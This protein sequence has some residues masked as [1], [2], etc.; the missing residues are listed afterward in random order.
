MDSFIQSSHKIVSRFY[1]NGLTLLVIELL[2]FLF[3]NGI[4]SELS[5]ASSV[6]SSKSA[7]DTSHSYSVN[8]SPWYLNIDDHWGGHL[9]VRGACSWP[10]SDSFFRARGTE[11][12]YDGHAEARVK[13]RLALTIDV[14]KLIN[15]VPIPSSVT[16]MVTS[17]RT[18]YLS[19][20]RPS[21]GAAIVY[22]MKNE[23]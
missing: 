9:K 4:G 21:I 18:L 11:A 3:I 5:L 7:H 2:F 6:S 13:N 12:L 17:H 20:S 16:N 8:P 14:E 22:A 1:Y 19:P 23:E 10:S 15:S